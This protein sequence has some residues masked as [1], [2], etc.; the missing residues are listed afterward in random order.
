VPVSLG[1]LDD[2]LRVAAS[3]GQ[4][5][6]VHELMQAG[7]GFGPDRVST[8]WNLHVLFC[9]LV[10][11]RLFVCLCGLVSCK[12]CVLLV[13]YISFACLQTVNLPNSFL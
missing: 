9:G 12:V 10:F 6:K 8:V 4:V 5:D 11:I 3:K 1:S 2:K 7:A 13:C